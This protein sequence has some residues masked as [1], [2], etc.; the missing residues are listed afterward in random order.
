MP[1]HVFISYSSGDLLA[2]EHVR[3]YLEARKI[4]NENISCWMAP[5]D[6][7]ADKPYSLQISQAIKECPIYLVLISNGSNRSEHVRN[8][9]D[10]AFSNNSEMLCYRLVNVKPADDLNYYLSRKKWIDGFGIGDEALD[11]LY[12]TVV[13]ALGGTI[14][15]QWWKKLFRFIR[16]LI[17]YLMFI[18]IVFLIVLVVKDSTQNTG[19]YNPTQ[20]SFKEI[21]SRIIDL[22]KTYDYKGLWAKMMELV[23]LLKQQN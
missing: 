14:V 5:R 13:K 1:K 6:C 7:G 21:F 16:K 3:D 8:E 9:V 17:G 2:A 12:N 18:A 23:S 20:H 22:V 4:G 19:V 10:L 11:E 15:V